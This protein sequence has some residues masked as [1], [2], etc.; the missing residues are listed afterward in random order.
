MKIVHLSWTI[1]TRVRRGGRSGEAIHNRYYRSGKFYE[2][3]TNI[4]LGVFLFQ[5]LKKINLYNN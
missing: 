5:L 1:L 3:S 2:K 4:N